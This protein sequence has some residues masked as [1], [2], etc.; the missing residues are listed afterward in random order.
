MTPVALDLRRFVRDVPDYPKPGIVFKDLT[1]LWKDPAA[2]QAMVDSLAQHFRSSRIE[3]VVAIESRGLIVGSALAF[4][5]G[6]GLVPV[7]KA[8]KLP[9]NTVKASYSLEYGEATSEIHTDAFGQGTRVLIVDDLLATGGTAEAAVK[10]VRE[11]KGEVVGLAFLVE[12]TFLK[13]CERLRPYGVEIFSLLQ[14]DQP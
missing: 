11:L 9:W 14:Y 2:F 10:L 7:R 5:L 3:T 6:A 4:V 13:G 8:G 12:L 1:P